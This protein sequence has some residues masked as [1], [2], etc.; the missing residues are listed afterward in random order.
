MTS[1][2]S[3]SPAA[4]GCRDGDLVAAAFPPG[5]VT[6]APKVRALEIIHELEATPRDV[7][8]GT[9][10][11]R[12]PLAGLELNVAIRT[13]EFTAGR[14]WLG[15]GVVNQLIVNGERMPAIARGDV[16]RGEEAVRALRLRR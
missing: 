11:Y 10:G 15:S 4:S 3:A 6:G 5:S 2:G 1:A 8:T 14:V 16:I 13:F 12:S 9:I 7:Y